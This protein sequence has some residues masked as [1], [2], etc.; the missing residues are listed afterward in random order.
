MQ[1]LLLQFRARLTRQQSQTGFTMIELLVVIAI[2]GILA[3][4]VIGTINPVE[5]INRGRDTRTRADAGELVNA[6]ERYFA[7]NEEYPWNVTVTGTYTSAI[8]DLPDSEY[9]FNSIDGAGNVNAGS[10][11]FAWVEELAATGE[12]KEGFTNRILGTD[13]LVLFKADGANESTYTCFIPTSTAFKREA[14]ENCDDQ[15]TPGSGGSAP[16][17]PT[18]LTTCVS[19]PAVE[20]EDNFLCLP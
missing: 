13:E 6:V 5:Q 10:D 15:V 4:A 11:E 9:A 3:V 14:A 8:A 18:G 7:I 17:A 12:V 1:K 19:T 16:A 20:T 2:I